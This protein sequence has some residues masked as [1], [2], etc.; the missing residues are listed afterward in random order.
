M[1]AEPNAEAGVPADAQ[2]AGEVGASDQGPLVNTEGDPFKKLCAAERKG[3]DARRSK[4]EEAISVDEPVTG[5]ALSGGGIRSATFSLGILQALSGYGLIPRIDYLSTVSGGSYI[6]SFFGALFVPETHRGNGELSGKALAFDSTK[7]LQSE[8]GREAVRRLREAGRY[9]TPGGT[10]DA[11]FG[12]ALVLRN[13]AAVHFVFGM[14]A[15]L[16]FWS[17]RL[18]D[19]WLGAKPGDWS[20]TLLRV[21]LFAAGAVL[22]A[23]TSYWLTRREWIPGNRFW[24]AVSNGFFWA[25]V[26][27]VLYFSVAWWK[28]CLMDWLPLFPGGGRLADTLHGL[29]AWT[30]PAGF[31]PGFIASVLGL[32]L[33][34]YVGME[35]WHGGVEHRPVSDEADN[36][37]RKAK[38]AKD[39]RNPQYLIAA[40]DRV[41]TA[42]SN[43]MTRALMALVAIAALLVVVRFGDLVEHR[44]RQAFTTWG[45]GGPTLPDLAK[46][47]PLLATFIP[48]VMSYLASTRLKSGSGQVGN[49]WLE[50]RLPTIVGIAGLSLL[51]LWLVIW[52]AVAAWAFVA[53]NAAGIKAVTIFGSQWSPACVVVL[54]LVLAN[55]ILGMS[56]SFINLSSLSTFYAARL[57]RAYVG[58]SSAG[59]DTGSVRSDNPQ[60]TIRLDRYYSGGARSLAPL[61]LINVTIAE[62][63]TGDSNL[64]ARDRKGKP[65]HLSPRGIVY[66]GSHPGTAMVGEAGSFPLAFGEELPLANWVAI[67]GAAVSA[68]IGSGTSLGT[69]IL[70]TLGNVRLGYWWKDTRARKRPSLWQR[71]RDFIAAMR[72]LLGDRA[73]A[74]AS[75]MGWLDALPVNLR[76]F[77]QNYLLLELRGAFAGTRRRRWY[78]TD[79]GHFE[80]TGAYALLQRRVAFIII[81]DNG[82]DPQ[83][84]M[85]DMVRLMGRARTDLGAKIHFLSTAEIRDKLKENTDLIGLI[86]EFSALSKSAEEGAPGPV[87]AIAR[88]DYDDGSIGT[89]LLVKPRL[90]LAEPPEILAYREGR[91]HRDFPQQTTA[92]QFF[93][94]AQWEA[95]RRL[96]EL[97]GEK[98]FGPAPA[99]A[100]R[101]WRPASM[102]P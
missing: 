91:G 66:E 20:P 39:L 62:T 24:R 58:A 17:L 49:N 76:D 8:A 101:G 77:V 68:A 59:R 12:A 30:F 72:K 27:A 18:A 34:L 79:G 36:K 75:V 1:Q 11:F 53:L 50:Q 86:G 65:M 3:I 28:Q 10:S 78:L 63:M 83:Y 5:L 73:T 38:R 54:P 89:L 44:L 13:W 25:I 46:L 29:G 71:A 56:F 69:S 43:G 85:S 70:A 32:A 48:P 9:L 102:M 37:T 31:L 60:D 80:N 55:L 26:A 90:T 19:Q 84:E 98:L 99:E 16:L 47:W 6:G 21:T 51:V 35:F 41:R 96:G 82:A 67:S 14:V 94:E 64:V 61:H 81:C 95:Y 100:R 74:R 52:S 23:G 45:S 87:A 88:I 33:L 42:L 7:P 2:V 97:T 22:A 92:D 15:L 93:D 4:F 57:R 40:E